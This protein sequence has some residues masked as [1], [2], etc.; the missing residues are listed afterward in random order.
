ML[1]SPKA[2]INY[3]AEYCFNAEEAF[4]LEGDNKF[5]KVNIANQLAEIRLHKRGPRPESGYIDYFYK[6]SKH[7][8]DNI[9][10]FKWIPNS[11]GK[12]KI[13]EHPVWSEI[14]AEKIN[15]LRQEAADRGENIDL[16][17]YKEM[18]D[19]YIAG[20]DGIDIGKNQ[21]SKETRNASDFCITI[22]K[23]ANGL[24][25]PQ[26]VAMYKDRPDD[27][28]TAYKT[29]LCLLK[30]YNCK[31]NIEATRVG[32][33]TWARENKCL[34]YFIKRPRATLTD[35]KRGSS[36]QYGTPATA[37]IIDQHTDLTAAF[38]EDY[39]HTIWFEEILDQLNS[40]NDENK[41]K[42]DIIAA[43][44]MTF[45]A[46][47]ELSGRVPTLVEQEV[48][49]FEDYG[50]YYD[51]RG[52]KRFGVIPKLDTTIQFKYKDDYDPYRIETSDPRLYQGFI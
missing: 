34:Q 52:I 31:V 40:Y 1:N 26:I 33:V 6:S 10:G 13:L 22:L 32:F 43:L 29:A 2:L 20:I 45:L 28:R 37:T 38:V 44:G 27:I 8:L 36:K 16:P 30:Y 51:E 15:K 47:Q 18:N 46:D 39:C 12:V 23:R 25:D 17:I 4:A 48:E 42:F 9:D 11:K 5:N 50:Y 19:L 49:Q 7:S 21:T 14:Y 41:G 24:N 3:S 35:I